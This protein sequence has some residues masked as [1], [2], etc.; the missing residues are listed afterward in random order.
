VTKQWTSKWPAT[1]NAVFRIVQN[2]DKKVT[3]VSFRGGNRQPPGSTP[4]ATTKAE[5]KL[6]FAINLHLLGTSQ[7]VAGSFSLDL[8]IFFYYCLYVYP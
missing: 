4:A 6:K 8:K 3:F 2:Y 7:D 5:G 1:T